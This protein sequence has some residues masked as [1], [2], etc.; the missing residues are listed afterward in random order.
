MGTNCTTFPHTRRCNRNKICGCTCQ[1]SPIAVLESHFRCHNLPYILSTAL[2]CK[3][4]SIMNAEL[5]LGQ[6][7][8]VKKQYSFSFAS[9]FSIWVSLPLCILHL[10]LATI[11]ANAT[12]PVIA[13]HQSLICPIFRIK[14][15][16]LLFPQQ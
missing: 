3:P 9:F 5:A 13:I 8:E 7:A 2:T 14:C 6:E 15:K 1:A 16:D 4:I 11:S 12:N 10:N